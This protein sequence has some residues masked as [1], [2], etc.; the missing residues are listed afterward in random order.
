MDYEGRLASGERVLFRQIRPS[1]KERL[2]KGFQML[3]PESRYRRFF[4][5]M[6]T[7]SEAQLAYLTELD[8]EDHYA[9]IGVLPDRPGEPGLGVAR[10][11]RIS[12]EPE[13]A[14]G[15]VTVLDAYHGQGLGST[16]L[17]LA[18]RS[19][20]EKGVKAFRVWVQGDNHPMLA[21]LEDIGT[22][23]TQW[24]AGVSEIDIPLPSDPEDLAANP[25]ALVLRAV[26]SGDVEGRAE[27]ERSHVG[28][29]LVDERES[30][31]DRT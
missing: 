15:A 19:A 18:A 26:A 12:D 7:L 22:T 21:I 24:E 11:I 29:R 2:L 17:W 31:P 8:F 20:I 30:A 9:W 28:T 16:L 14:E 4:R 25:A 13:V 27:P 1:D 10:W 6:D 23:P 3:S 5:N